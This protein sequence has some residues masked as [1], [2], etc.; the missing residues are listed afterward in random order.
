MQTLRNCGIERTE[1]NLIELV[2]S[3]P[4]IGETLAAIVISEI[5]DVERFRNIKALTAFAGLDPRVRQSGVTLSRNSRLTK[6][7]SPYLRRALFIAASIAQRHDDVFKI[8]YAKKRAEGKRYTEATI[9]NARHIL[10]RVYAV[11]KRGTPYVIHS[12]V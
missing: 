3:I 5:G 6:R 12:S 1:K 11:W 8:Y 7:G 2:S 4:G 9:A 10:Q